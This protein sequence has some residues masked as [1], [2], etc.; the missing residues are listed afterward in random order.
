VDPDLIHDELEVAGFG[1]IAVEAV[2]KVSRAPSPR[3]VAIGLCQGTPLRSE[4]EARAPNRLDKAKDQVAEV[5]AAR[6]GSFP[7]EAPMKAY[8]VSP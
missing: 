7:P 4:I 8:V 2:E 3:D 1:R 5:L 6:Y